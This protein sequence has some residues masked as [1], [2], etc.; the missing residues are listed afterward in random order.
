[1]PK[2]EAQLED[3]AAAPCFQGKVEEKQQKFSLFLQNNQL[4]SVRACVCVCLYQ[5]VLRDRTVTGAQSSCKETRLVKTEIAEQI[6][7]M[8]ICLNRR[9]KR[10]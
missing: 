7:K 10:G 9:R 3:F 5:T 4:Q 2:Q 1:M 8:Y 6:H